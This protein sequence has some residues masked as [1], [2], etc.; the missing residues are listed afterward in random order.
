MLAVGGQQG[1][2]IV[3]A[4]DLSPGA[5]LVLIDVGASGGP[6]HRWLNLGDKVEIIGFEPDSRAA[7]SL[8][9]G[10]GF[11]TVRVALYS[12]A[13]KHRFYRTRKQECSSLFPPNRAFVNGF[14]ESDRFDVIGTG[15]IDVDTL[16][17][18]VI[19]AEIGDPD[20][21][22]LDVQG[23]E[24]AVL[25][26]ATKTLQQQLVGVQIEVCFVPLYEGQP[27]FSDVD[28]FLREFGFELFDLSCEF[29]KRDS[30]VG[31]ARGQLVFAD[32][33]YLK[34]AEATSSLVGLLEDRYRSAKALKAAAVASLYGYQDH[35]VHVLEACRAFVDGPSYTSAYG[36]LSGQIPLERR[37]P[38]FPGRRK[39]ANLAYMAY[40]LVRPRY[41]ADYPTRY[42]RG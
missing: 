23:A 11:R 42:N 15:E 4:I 13:G 8:T 10:P 7:E 25:R 24:L 27:L 21:L 22:K 35:G 40:R 31:D 32:A 14:P 34:S 28:T 33:L 36:A 17:R 1:S 5:P 38:D 20:F 19:A 18:Q 30:R 26:G 16:D 3:R 9:S 39:V 12:E 6:P 41:W 37:V 29:W 2:R